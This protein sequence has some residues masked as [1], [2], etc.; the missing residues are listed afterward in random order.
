MNSDLEWGLKQEKKI[1]PVLEEYFGYELEDTPQN[2]TF[3][4]INSQEKVVIE[5]KSRKINKNQYPTTMVGDNKWRKAKK[6]KEDGWEI[7]FVF[8]FRDVKCV[9]EFDNQDILRKTGGRTDRGKREIKYY[10]F[11]PIS[12]L[13]DI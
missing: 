3:D 12:D 2:D 13:K 10:R 7:F 4:Y 6:L 9:Y 8:N 5:V 11:I 1:K